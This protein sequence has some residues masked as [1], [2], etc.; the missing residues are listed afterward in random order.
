MSKVDY[1]EKKVIANH[2]NV[3]CLWLY[4]SLIVHTGIRLIHCIIS[5]NILLIVLLVPSKKR[6][7]KKKY[8]NLEGYTMYLLKE[9][10]NPKQ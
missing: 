5:Q 3:Y 4:S 7:G 2:V 10:L 9:L 8:K 6:K 1:R